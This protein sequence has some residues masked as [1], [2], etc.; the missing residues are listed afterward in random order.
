VLSTLLFFSYPHQ[1]TFPHGIRR[2][3][4][5]TDPSGRR[6]AS[7]SPGHLAVYSILLFSVTLLHIQ[8]V[9][10]LLTQDLSFII[11]DVSGQTW[12]TIPLL[13]C[14][15]LEWATRQDGWRPDNLQFTCR[16]INHS[17]EIQILL[18]LL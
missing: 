5:R 13:G 15:N 12:T 14:N 18:I 7:Q 1:W 3:M 4:S 10:E 11:I 2:R 6:P 8:W 17:P 16:N 9:V